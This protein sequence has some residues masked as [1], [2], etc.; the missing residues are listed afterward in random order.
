MEL[1]RSI[2]EDISSGAIVQS[3]DPNKV[4]L[5]VDAYEQ[6]A[7][8][9][10][11]LMQ[12]LEVL[13]PSG[14]NDGLTAFERQLKRFG[15][16]THSN[17][18]K[19][20]WSSPGSYFFQENQPESKILFPAWIQQQAIWSRLMINDVNELLATTRSI[21]GAT[22]ESL[23][24]DDSEILALK[25]KKFR[26][27]ERGRFPTVKISWAEK[28]NKVDKH[29]VAID[30]S[31]E[32][33]RRINLE[34]LGTVVARIMAYDRDGMY[35]DAV[36]LM[37]NGDGTS[38]NPAA[39]V[40]TAQSLDA[41]NATTGDISYE[42]WLKWLALWRPFKPTLV[43]GNVD[44]LVKLL[45]MARPN[46]DPLQMMALLKEIKSGSIGGAINTVRDGL[47]YFPNVDFRPVDSTVMAD[48][49]ILG[50]DPTS[51]IERII[52]VGSDLQET[53]K[54]IENQTTKLVISIADNFSKIW[55]DA[56]KV[57]SLVAT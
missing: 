27:N 43:I 7:K 25:G 52:E 15:I 1:A 44:T 54:Y 24:I 10:L 57:L 20:I 41:T 9:G 33:V 50:V 23:S 6:A 13:N 18:E 53:K 19:G 21:V 55:P 48:N 16:V 47:D 28:A 32:F 2:F 42:A 34:L 12:Y 39:T 31:Y 8:Y 26:V 51:A 29:G 40:T 36:D 38:A 46:S 17:P 11:N 49:L 30:A 4:R 5:T 37:L 35:N 22:Y 45:T 56:C 14:D 3:A